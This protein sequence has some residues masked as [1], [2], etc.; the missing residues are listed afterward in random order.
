MLVVPHNV[1]PEP[2]PSVGVPLGQVQTFAEQPT[3][4]DHTPLLQLDWRFKAPL[5]PVLQEKLTVDE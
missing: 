4:A 2:V 5:K 1:V 3:K